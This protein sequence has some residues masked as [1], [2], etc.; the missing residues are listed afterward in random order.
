MY[1]WKQYKN[2]NWLIEKKTNVTPKI[3][4]DTKEIEYIE[5][6]KENYSLKIKQ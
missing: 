2:E 3:N 6:I 5:L 4:Q 1:F